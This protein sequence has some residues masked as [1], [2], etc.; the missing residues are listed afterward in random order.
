MTQ[1]AGDNVFHM[2][3]CVCVCV[4]NVLKQRVSGSGSLS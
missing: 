4:F 2:C 3:V 1:T